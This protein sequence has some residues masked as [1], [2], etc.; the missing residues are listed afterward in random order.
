MSSPSTLT[1]GL[2]DGGSDECALRRLAES[3]ASD[4]ALCRV[5][6]EL[7]DLPPRRVNE[8]GWLLLAEGVDHEWDDHHIASVRYEWLFSDAA[9]AP[10]SRMGP[11]VFAVTVTLSAEAD[12]RAFNRWYDTTH[13]PEVAAAGLTQARRY[14]RTDPP[15]DPPTEYLAIYTMADRHTLDS[16]ELGK[17]RGFGPFTPHVRDVRRFVLQQVSTD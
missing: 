16:E 14:R 5:L 15:F 8:T 10:L 17:V 13:V 4:G 1:V 12:E 3:A 2:A 11:W 6:D 7:V 9:A